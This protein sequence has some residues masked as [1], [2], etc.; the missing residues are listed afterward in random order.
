MDKEDECEACGVPNGV[1]RLSYQSRLLNS[2]ILGKVR[3]WSTEEAA[4]WIAAR[5]HKLWRR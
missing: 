2:S 4:P 5:M 3:L 1:F